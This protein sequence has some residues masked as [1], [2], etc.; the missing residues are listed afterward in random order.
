MD[1]KEILEILKTAANLKPEKK[2]WMGSMH[3]LGSGAINYCPECKD[4]TSYEYLNHHYPK[5]VR[6]LESL[7][8]QHVIEHPRNPKPGDY[9]SEPGEYL[10]M[11]D[12]NEHEVVCNTY[13][14]NK[15]G[16]LYWTLYNETH[17]KWWMPWPSD[18]LDHIPERK[19]DDNA[20]SKKDEDTN[21]GTKDDAQA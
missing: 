15:N 14:P 9:P 12:A 1:T 5:M 21:A 18:I 19:D 16:D 2:Y 11:L 10:T 17:I 20:D 8:W 4:M 6:L 7:P 13:H 3:I